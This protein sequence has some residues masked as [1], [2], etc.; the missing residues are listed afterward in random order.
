MKRF[1]YFRGL[2]F[3]TALLFFALIF[4][5]CNQPGQKTLK[6]RQDSVDLASYVYNSG[7]LKDQHSFQRVYNQSAMPLPIRHDSVLKMVSSYG[8]HKLLIDPTSATN[9]LYFMLDASDW[10]ILMSTNK[11]NPIKSLKFQF[12]VKNFGAADSGTAPP[13]YTIITTPVF[14]GTPPAVVPDFDYICPCPSTAACC[15]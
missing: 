10:V 5:S 9:P 6:T 1:F 4:D 2:F 3:A 11:N 7:I 15:N 14:I 8:N 13:I 12:G